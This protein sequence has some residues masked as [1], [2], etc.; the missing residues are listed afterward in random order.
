MYDQTYDVLKVA[1]AA[2]VASGTATLETALLNTPQVVCYAGNKISYLIAKLLVKG[3]VS[4]VNIIMNA[5]VVKELIQGDMSVEKMKNEVQ[6]LLFDKAYR[7]AQLEAY[8][9]LRSSLGEYGSSKR[10]AEAMVEEL[11]KNR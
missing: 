4:L 7:N 1:D 9:Q 3:Y 8:K 5:P 11:K 10:V 6:A 2:I